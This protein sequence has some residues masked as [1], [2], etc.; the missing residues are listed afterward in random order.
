MQLQEF[1]EDIS[2]NNEDQQWA[3][4]FASRNNFGFGDSDDDD[5]DWDSPD[6]N[7]VVMDILLCHLYVL[8]FYWEYL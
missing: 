6:K 1:T 2:V 3:K 5:D 7:Y 8:N 4:R